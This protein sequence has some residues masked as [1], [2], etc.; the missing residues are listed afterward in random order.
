MRSYCNILKESKTIAIIGI[1][2]K[3]GRVSGHIA[4]FLRDEGYNVVGV[5]PTLSNVKGIK[6]YKSL[7][8][9]LYLT[10]AIKLL[11]FFSEHPE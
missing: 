2:N 1:S 10:A 11:D 5:H 6:V 3:P 8:R 9:F 4:A 7:S